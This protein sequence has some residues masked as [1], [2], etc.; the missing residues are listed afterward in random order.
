M[1]REFEL[2]ILVPFGADLQIAIADPFRV[3]LKN[4]FDFKFVRDIE[5]LQS[6]PDCEQFVPSLR[7]EPN[8]AAQIVSRLCLGADDM[9]PILFI[10]DEHAVIFPRPPF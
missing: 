5:F 3:I 9:L 2:K 7:I 10:R 4:A 1:Q 8:L 6:G